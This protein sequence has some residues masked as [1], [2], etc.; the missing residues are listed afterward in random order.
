MAGFI[1]QLARARRPDRR[2]RGARGRLRRGRA[3]A[4]ASRAAACGSAA[5][6]VSAEVIA[7][8]R[9]RA[10]AA[11]VERRSSEVAPVEEL[12]PAQRRRRA[13]R[14]LRGAWS[15]SP[16]RRG[17]SSRGVARVAVGDR[18]RPARAAL[19][20]PQP[21][22]PQVPGRARQHAGAPQPL[23]AALLSRVS[24]DDVSRSSSCAARCPG[25]W[26]CAGPAEASYTFATVRRVRRMAEPVRARP[27]LAAIVCLGIA[28]GLVMHSMG[29]AQLAHFAQ[30]RA[31]ADGQANIDRW[32]WET[33]DKAW[34]DGHFYSVKAPGLAAAHPAR[35]HGA[36]R[37][38]RLVGVDGRGRHTQATRR[39]R[40]GRRPGARTRTSCS[41]ASTPHRALRVETQVEDETPIVWALTLLGAVIPAL[42]L[43]LLVRWAGDRVQPGYGTAAAITLGLGT[44]VMTFAAEYFSHVVVGRT[45]VRRL[46]D[47]LSR[48]R[49][50]AAPSAGRGRR[51]GR[52]PRGD[53]RV[54]ARPA[55]GHPPRLR[56]V[57][58][59]ASSA[60][61][62]R[63]RRHRRGRRHTGARLQ[64]VGARV[65]RSTSPTPQRSPSRA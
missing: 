28:W 13:D 26:P 19:A 60:T 11:G 46:R 34:I 38:R 41:T 1:R 44:I 43:L 37:R 64:L 47:P 56:A 32:H 16:I 55:R 33:K 3:G 65:S 7:E 45:G 25:R 14:L 9:A 17:R 23:V 15:T 52:G 4:G 62:A 57:T 48:A 59:L 63:L 36:E 31:L 58:P 8:A 39:T 27:G 10:E 20:R 21:G 54:P 5:R 53:V 42:V 29:W 22:A 2:A 40:G 50:A 12:E 30:V 61:R 35:V 49:G 51:A 18:Q 6:D 24:R